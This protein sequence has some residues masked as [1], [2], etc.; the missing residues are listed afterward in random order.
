MI[1]RYFYMGISY[2]L[3]TSSALAIWQSK[4]HAPVCRVREVAGPRDICQ[5]AFTARFPSGALQQLVDECHYR[6]LRTKQRRRSKASQMISEN[7]AMEEA[8]PDHTSR[9]RWY[10]W[11]R[12]CSSKL[13]LYFA[14]PQILC[15][16][17]KR[18]IRWILTEG[19]V[20][21]VVNPSTWTNL[22]K[23]EPGTNGRDYLS[24]F[25]V[26]QSYVR[27]L[28]CVRWGRV[29]ISN[30]SPHYTVSLDGMHEDPENS[31]A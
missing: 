19:E 10:W 22:N 11:S 1:E 3:F 12:T 20:E 9:H 30:V 24:S 21:V 17:E 31:I 2:S 18:P 7:R 4:F 25:L 14:E 28:F 29:R 15:L 23:F 8:Q 26:L 27:N 16:W 5:A 6:T 13:C